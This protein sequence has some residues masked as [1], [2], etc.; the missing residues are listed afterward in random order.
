MAKVFNQN[1]VM[2]NYLTFFGAGQGKYYGFWDAGGKWGV[3]GF[4][5]K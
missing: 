2:S 3:F 4:V 1:Y 5:G